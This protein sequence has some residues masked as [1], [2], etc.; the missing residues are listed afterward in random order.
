MSKRNLADSVERDEASSSFVTLTKKK[1]TEQIIERDE[2]TSFVA[3]GFCDDKCVKSWEM[4]NVKGCEP[5]DF[6][7]HF[8]YRCT[9]C[10][11][12]HDGLRGDCTHN[13]YDSR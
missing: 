12:V 3:W 7:R 4:A 11:H 9:E 2:E 13:F 5:Y 6:C 10:G 8:L 1:M